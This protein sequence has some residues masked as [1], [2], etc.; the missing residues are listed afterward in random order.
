MKKLLLFFVPMFFLASCGKDI[1]K[2]VVTYQKATPIYED[3]D[4]MRQQP[5]ISAAR[6]V[7]NPGKIFVSDNFLLIGE[8]GKGIHLVDNSNP[9]TPQAVFFLNIPFNREF[10][11]EDNVLYAESQYD[12]LK[13]DISTIAAPRIIARAENTFGEALMDNDGNT[14]VGFEFEQVTEEME[15]SSELHSAIRQ[16]NHHIYYDYANNI[17][18]PSAVPSSF[19][20]NSSGDIGTVNRIALR[21][22]YVYVLGTSKISVLNNT[23]TFELANT[24]YLTNDMETI[25]AKDDKLFIGTRNSMMVLGLA[26]PL[27]PNTETTYWHADSCDP[28]LPDD[29]VAYVTLRTGDEGDCPGDINALL[30]IDINSDNNW[31]QELQ[32]IEM[33]SPY[34]M[35][36]IGDNLFVGEGQHGLKIFDATDRKNIS[37]IH[38]DEQVEAYDVIPHPSRTDLVLVA[39]PAGLAQYELTSD[40]S[41]QIVSML[42]F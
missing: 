1:G 36:M 17:I 8:E 5:L 4:A 19:A 24:R 14:L 31:A 22:D 6:N 27:S 28:V 12:M 35:T 38:F 21:G 23:G 7:E 41:L 25:Y 9:S 32:E 42:V 40:N 26:D 3:L 39:G 29:E 16:N 34:G 15:V 18:P 2:V 33:L 37:L 20:G 30:V 10:F 13:I 11:V